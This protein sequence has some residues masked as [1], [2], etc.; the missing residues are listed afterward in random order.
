MHE[1]LLEA[2]QRYGLSK[3]ALAR[4]APP[5]P[6]EEEESH[7]GRNLAVAGAAASPFAGLIGQDKILHD[8]H[9]D[10][11]MRRFRSM[12]D[13]S[14][15]AQPGDLLMTTKPN[16]SMWKA[17]ISPLSGS[18]FYHAQPVIGRRGGHGTTVSAGEHDQPLFRKQVSTKGGIREFIR[19]TDKVHEMSQNQHYPDVMLLRPKRPMTPE[20][21]KAFEQELVQRTTHPYSPG[22]A[23]GTWLKEIFMPKVFDRSGAKNNAPICEGNVCSTMPAQAY[24]SQ[25]VNVLPNKRSQDIFPTDFLR[26]DQ[27]EP[28]GVRLE[29]QYMTSP[30]MRKLMPY[31]ARGALGAGLAGATY[32]ISKDPALAAAP[33]GLMAGTT[34]ATALGKH[35]YSKRQGKVPNTFELLNG[36]FELK[37]KKRNNMLKK[38]LGVRAPLALGGAAASYYGAKKL[39]EL[40]AR[41]RA[42]ANEG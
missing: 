42:E 23:I 22:K 20:Q 16:R 19:N 6:E 4:V 31:L 29:N 40:L 7:T 8:P 26:S 38:Y 28:V 10:P 13:L 17:T 39:E 35:L 12:G 21:L 11:N 3:E 24:A 33:L 27:F 36:L 1:A 18:E 9:L 2:M 30:T 15:A 37:G 41:R 5:P 14:R 34:A 32:G 25:G